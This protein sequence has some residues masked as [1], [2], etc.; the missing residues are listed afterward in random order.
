[1]GV[2]SYTRV[3]QHV[4]FLGVERCDDTNGNV[5]FMASP[6][7]ALADYLYVH[8]LNW[9][10][11]DEPIGSLRIDADELACVSAEE[12]KALLSNYGNGRV[13]R[14]MTGWLGEVK[15]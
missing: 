5:F 9:T 1:M 8:Q 11:I 4:F 7:K 6:A 10:G 2:F 14:F 12:L 15:S 3:P 13:N